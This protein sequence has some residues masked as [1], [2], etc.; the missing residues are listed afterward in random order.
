MYYYGTGNIQGKLQ[1]LLT[2]EKIRDLLITNE[3]PFRSHLWYLGAIL[4]V[5]ILAAWLVKRKTVLDADP[6]TLSSCRRSNL[7]KV[8]PAFMEPGD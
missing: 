6:D 1:K 8:F 4:Y 2:P 7:W 5:L 3:S